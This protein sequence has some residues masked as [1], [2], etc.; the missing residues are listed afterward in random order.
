MKERIK[1]SLVI[2]CFFLTVGIIGTLLNFSLVV[3]NARVISSFPEDDI[4]VKEEISILEHK[5][6]KDAS[7]NAKVSGVIKNNLGRDLDYLKVV[8]KF[9]DNQGNLLESVS[10]S[11][12]YLASFETWRFSVSYANLE[13]YPLEDYEI[14]VQEYQ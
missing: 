2:T 7:G 14:I 11:I 1:F 5:L 13:N 12:D 8:V 10:T 3:S 9:Y 4:L 6:E